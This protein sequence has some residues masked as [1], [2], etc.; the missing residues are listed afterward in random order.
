MEGITEYTQ[1]LYIPSQAPFDLWNR[2]KAAGVK[3][4]VKRVF[5]MDEAEAL[6]PTYLRFVKGVIDS[7]DL[8][9]NVS[10]EL[11]QESRDVKAIRE[12]STKR[13]LGM[14]ED[15]AKQEKDESA[16]DEDKGKYAKFYAEFGAVLKEGLGE[17]F[18]NR[19]RIA[20][21]LRFA[22]TSS[23]TASV[24]LADYKARM[25]EGQEAIYY[26]TGRH[27][28]RREE[29]PAARSLPQEGH[30]GAA[31]DRPR[32]RMGAQ[33]P[34]GVRRHA[35]AIGGQGRGRPGQAAGRGR[36]EGRRGSGR[37][38]QARAGETEGSA[39]GQGPG[40]ARHHH[41]W[42]IRPPAWS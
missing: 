38:L 26:I 1:L 21:L 24:P 42:S 16:T 6:L 30:R 8:P 10:R 17:D 39:Q 20:K 12:G 14:L 5:I 41:A 19:E 32:G 36:E 25:K 3:L 34:A 2:E 22:S 11:L 28:G 15:L 40:R 7:A 31:D 27:A 13:V 33:L 9:L 37:S 4:Y 35:A 23:D 29:Q 18:A